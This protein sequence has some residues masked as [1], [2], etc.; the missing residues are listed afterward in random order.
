MRLHVAFV[1]VLSEGGNSSGQISYR[2][3]DEEAPADAAE[4]VLKEGEISLRA[5]KTTSTA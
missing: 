3:E 1:P 2:C 5:A 4:Q